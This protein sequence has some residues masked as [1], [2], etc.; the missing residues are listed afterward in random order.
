MYTHCIYH[1]QLTCPYGSALSKGSQCVCT[2]GF[3][4]TAFNSSMA[5]CEK[6]PNAISVHGTCDNRIW[7]YVNGISVEGPWPNGGY[8]D[9]IPTLFDPETD[10]LTFIGGDYSDYWCQ[11]YFNDIEISLSH[12]Q[13]VGQEPPS[14]W[15]DPSFDD[16]SWPFAVRNRLGFWATQGRSL[17]LN[18][19]IVTIKLLIS[20]LSSTQGGRIWCRYH[21]IA[22]SSCDETSQLYQGECWCSPGYK[23]DTGKGPCDPCDS[24]SHSTGIG[25]TVCNCDR[26]YFSFNGK[27]SPQEC[28]P[29]PAYSYCDANTAGNDASVCSCGTQY[30][31]DWYVRGDNF[32]FLESGSWPIMTRSQTG[33]WPCEVCPENTAPGYNDAWGI[34]IIIIIIITAYYY[35]FENVVVPYRN[36]QPCRVKPA[37]KQIPLYKVN[38]TA[39]CMEGSINNECISHKAPVLSSKVAFF[40][41]SSNSG[42]RHM[43]WDWYYV[44]NL[45]GK[46][47]TFLH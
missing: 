27:D 21:R 30:N 42:T 4:S 39:V 23:S 32:D 25:S 11:I 31:R 43:K 19:I 15:Q 35:Y 44:R 28:Q 14:N 6:I 47:S 3:Q 40:S 22:T 37:F 10:S 29:C 24:N 36:S 2:S 13:C 5:P 26:D 41:C 1:P 20:S 45:I 34:G 8:R 38:I 18:I 46:S 7:L 12:F 33:F 17:Q 16:S 9:S